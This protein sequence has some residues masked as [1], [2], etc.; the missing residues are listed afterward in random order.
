MSYC[1]FVNVN[2]IVIATI[3]A[4]ISEKVDFIVVMLIE[5]QTERLIPTKGENIE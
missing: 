3:V 2:L 4:L 5:F 1:S